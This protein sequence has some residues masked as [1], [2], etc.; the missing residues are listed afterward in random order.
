V[1]AGEM[2][3]LRRIQYQRT[4]EGAFTRDLASCEDWRAARE[5]LDV[6]LAGEAELRSLHARMLAGHAERAAAGEGDGPGR[7]TRVMAP[8]GAR[9]VSGHRRSR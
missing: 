7:G 6:S 9:R 4:G 3:G 8:S 2:R 5:S 1:A